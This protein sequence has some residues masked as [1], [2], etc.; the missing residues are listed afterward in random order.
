MFELLAETPKD[1]EIIDELWKEYYK[2]KEERL[3]LRE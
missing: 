1:Q 2:L 3:R